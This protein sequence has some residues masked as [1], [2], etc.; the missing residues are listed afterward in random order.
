MRGKLVLVNESINYSMEQLRAGIT[1]FM[2]IL[3]LQIAGFHDILDSHYNGAE[4]LCEDTDSDEDVDS[5]TDNEI[6]DD[7]CSIFSD[8]EFHT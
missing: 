1:S 7:N 5:D 3:G 8:Y 6:D 4:L 2:P